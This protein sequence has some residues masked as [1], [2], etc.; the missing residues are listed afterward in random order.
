MS[1]R[2]LI[3][4]ALLS[5]GC[6]GGQTGSIDE[7]A[8][9]AATA[10]APGARSSDLDLFD[11][12][13]KRR[14]LDGDNAIGFEPEDVTAFAV[15]E[16]SLSVPGADAGSA[17]LEVSDGDQAFRVDGE[18]VL[19]LELGVRTSLSGPVSGAQ[20]TWLVAENPNQAR[21]SV[22]AGDA[23]WIVTLRRDGTTDTHLGR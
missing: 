22:Q 4:C 23:V 15:G 12:S 14:P 9:T 16:H 18:C 19:A 3:A 21:L 17:L 13:V 10:T 20:D 1:L 6:A 2:G 8:G 5:C 11:C 7:G